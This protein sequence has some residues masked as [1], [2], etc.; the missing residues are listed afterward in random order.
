MKEDNAKSLAERNR[1]KNGGIQHSD[2]G[3]LKDCFKKVDR[4]C[5]LMSTTQF[6]RYKQPCECYICHLI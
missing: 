4:H 5:M 2:T 1:V 3:H 6:L